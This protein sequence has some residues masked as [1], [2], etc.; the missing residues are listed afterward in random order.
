MNI[1]SHASLVTTL[2]AAFL[3]AIPLLASL[4]GCGATS[5]PQESCKLISQVNLPGDPQIAA[6]FGAAAYKDCLL[7][8]ETDSQKVD[9]LRSQGQLEALKGFLLIGV[10]SAN[11]NTDSLKSRIL[12][13]SDLNTAVGFLSVLKLTGRFSDADITKL[14]GM[15][16][17][18]GLADA[19]HTSEQRGS[20]R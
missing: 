8:Y 7:G 14:D 4:T 6:L 2:L 13:A 1:R 18:L 3:A 16:P 9:A 11:A 19:I 5:N 17:H 10:Q 15:Y 12:A 20:P